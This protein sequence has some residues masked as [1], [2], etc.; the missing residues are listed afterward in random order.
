MQT[1]QGL[2]LEGANV[3]AVAK[4]ASTG[5]INNLLRNLM[6]RRIMY[7]SNYPSTVD[8][9]TASNGLADDME[10]HSLDYLGQK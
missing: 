10:K 9:L 5:R 6:L 8:I 4:L 2:S 7:V 3:D 1:G